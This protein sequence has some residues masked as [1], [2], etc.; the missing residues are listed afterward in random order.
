M[1]YTVIY[2]PKLIKVMKHIN[3]LFAL[4]LSLFFLSISCEKKPQIIKER[5]L[6]CYTLPE[7]NPMGLDRD[8]K[9]SVQKIG[10]QS[11]SIAISK[12][13]EKY[14]SRIEVLSKELDDLINSHYNTKG[15]KQYSEFEFNAIKGAY[16][17]LLAERR[18][19]MFFTH[20]SNITSEE[21]IKEIKKNGGHF[22]KNE[23]FIK[24]HNL[25]VE[26]VDL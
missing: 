10:H 2:S 23:N 3:C 20:D 6:I 7:N 14:R 15:T 22:Y 25:E 9:F 24:E 11:D 21:L 19:L 4:F 5:F 17:N 18:M 26:F 16:E 8:A 12:E 1:A 13:S